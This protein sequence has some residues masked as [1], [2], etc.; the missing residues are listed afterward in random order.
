M[1]ETWPIQPGNWT[2]RKSVLVYHR[3]GLRRLMAARFERWHCTISLLFQVIA[4]KTVLINCQMELYVLGWWQS[5][6]IMKQTGTLPVFF[7]KVSG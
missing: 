1:K 6:A 4:R 5:I 2:T 3:V 7:R